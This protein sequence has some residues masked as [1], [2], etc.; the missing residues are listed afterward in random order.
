RQSTRLAAAAPRL[1]AA[2]GRDRGATGSMRGSAAE[3]RGGGQRAGR[4]ALYGTAALVLSGARLAGRGVA[5]LR[6]R[7]H[8]GARLSRGS[9][10]QPEQRLGPLW[11]GAGPARP[12]RRRCNSHR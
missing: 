4:L 11:A 9:A 1:A 8:G 10:A 12:E 6:A 2:R 5:L 3:A 7:R